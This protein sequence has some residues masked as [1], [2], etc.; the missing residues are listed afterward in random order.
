MTVVIFYW[1]TN[2]CKG[3]YF[4]VTESVV[5]RNITWSPTCDRARGDIKIHSPRLCR[6]SHFVVLHTLGTNLNHSGQK[7]TK[8][9]LGVLD[10]RKLEHVPGTSPLNEL[11]HVGLEDPAGIESS[12]LKHD[13]TGRIVLV[14][15]PS[16]SPNDPYN[17]PKWRKRMYTVAIGYG[18]GCVG[19]MYLPA[20]SP[21]GD[22]GMCRRATQ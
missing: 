12:F 8:M 14:P 16:D 10:D 7:N 19:G 17:W 15:Q 1:D 13:P 6:L 22:D 20:Q 18:C 21:R 9:P 11:G 4:I 5:S 2:K 3:V